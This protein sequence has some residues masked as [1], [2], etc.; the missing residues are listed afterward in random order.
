M[1]LSFLGFVALFGADARVDT[2]A[3]CYDFAI[4][5]RIVRAGDIVAFGEPFTHRSTWRALVRRDSALDGKSRKLSWMLVT[6]GGVPVRTARFLMLA[7]AGGGRLPEVIHLQPLATRA[8]RR[9]WRQRL[10]A[11]GLH[12]CAN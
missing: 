1:F 12:R 5:G 6:S 10:R 2:T 9:R 11:A 8:D 3:R 4:V 7:R